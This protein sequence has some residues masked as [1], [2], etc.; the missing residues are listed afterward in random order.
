MPF[1]FQ[2]S[3]ELGARCHIL[4]NKTIYSEHHCLQLRKVLE[5]MINIQ[6]V[7]NWLYETQFQWFL[8]F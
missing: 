4:E 6:H 7:Y 3:G 2:H 5:H 8:R 1:V